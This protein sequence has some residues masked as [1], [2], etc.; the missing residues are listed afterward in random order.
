MR[1]EDRDVH[2]TEVVNQALESR[3]AKNAAKIMAMVLA[4]VITTLLAFIL[5]GVNGTNAN[6]EKALNIAQAGNDYNFKQDQAIA[7]LQQQ[8]ASDKVT[9]ST[10][11]ASLQVLVIQVTK[12]ADKVEQMDDTQKEILSHSR[13]AH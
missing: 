3:A 8:T 9:Q 2:G 12:L 13:P 11:V 4:A 5:A 6:S 10:T 7:L 1:K